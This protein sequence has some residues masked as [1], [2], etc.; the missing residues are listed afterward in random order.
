MS[1]HA[2]L[3]VT[4]PALPKGG[5]AIQGI[6]NGLGAIGSSGTASCEIPLPVSF[7]RGYAPA[8]AL[9]YSSAQ[10]NGVFG[11]GWK[12]TLPLVSRRTQLG[13]P[14]YTR[15]DLFISPDGEVLMPERN[16][17][18]GAIQTRQKLCSDGTQQV[19]HTIVR[20]RPRIES[21]FNLIEH[22]SSAKDDP[23]FWLIH[24]ADGSQHLFGKTPSARRADPDAPTHVGEWLLEESVNPHGEHIVY[25]YN[26]DPASTPEP[27]DSPAQR[28][29]ERV[30]YGNFEAE[31]QLYL[32]IVGG[33][34]D[35]RWHFEL[36]FDYG[37]R[38][39]V[40]DEK[41]A[42]QATKTSPVRSD[43]F[44]DFSY[45][46]ELSTRRLCQ[47]I[48]MFHH[49]P[50]EPSMGSEPV[51]VR[52][53][54][55]EYQTR[56][57]SYSCLSAALDQAYGKSTDERHPPLEFSYTDFSLEPG[58]ERFKPF[59]ALSG[60]NHQQ[61]F[62]FVDLLGE[63][64]PGVLHRTDKSWRYSQPVRDDNGGDRVTYKA[65]SELPQI[66]SADSRQPTRQCL[67]N[68]NANGRPDWILAQP[69]LSGF[70]TLKPNGTWSNFT[71]LDAVPT[72]FFHPH[73]QLANLMGAGL[74]DLVMLGPRSVRLYANQKGAGFASAT[75]VDRAADEDDLPLPGN[76]SSELVAFSDLLGS[77][78]QQ[79]V[80]IRRNEVKCW[81][82]L[83]R[84]RFGKGRVIDTPELSLEAFDASRLLLADL[85][86]SGS[87]D[88]IYLEPHCARIFMNLCGNGLSPAI[89]VPWPTGLRYDRFCQVSATDLQGL[90]CSSLVFSAPGE[91]PRHW[92]CDF[93][94]T[95]P[96]LLQS[97]N[98]NMGA[99]GSLNYRSSA[100]EWLDEK[101]QVLK[102]KKSAVS[103]LPFPLFLVKQQTRLDEITGNRLI[104]K[105]KY[106][107]GFYDGTEREFRGFGL[108]V[109]TDMG[110]DK[111]SNRQ[112]APTLTKTWFH[113]GNE[114]DLVIHDRDYSDE[115]AVQLKETLQNLGESWTPRSD[116]H[117]PANTSSRARRREI[118]RAL[119]GRVLR[120]EVYGQ[121]QGALSKLP[122]S[123]QHHRYKVNELKGMGR[124]S[125][126]SIL[127][128][129]LAESI[130]YQYER[131][132]QDP[133]CT[134][135][136]NLN[137]DA[138]GYLT[139]H[140]E[141]SYARR[142][143][144]DDACPFTD[145]WNKKWWGDAHDEAQQFYYVT[146]HKAQFI[147][148]NTPQKR[149]L[150][151][152]YLQR[153]NALK[154]PKA[155]V[156]EGLSPSTIN[157]EALLILSASPAWKARQV[158][159]GLSLQ[160]YRKPDASG[161]FADG[162]ASVEALV[163]H[164][165]TA[166]LNELALDVYDLLKSQDA[167]FD[168]TRRL[169]LAGYK[170]MPIALPG[171]A[172]RD[173]QDKLWSVRRDFVT[174][175]KLEGFFKSLS[176]KQ[177]SQQGPTTFTH[178]PYFCLTTGLKLPDNCTTTASNID[179]RLLQPTQITDSND[180]V[181]EASLDAF[182]QVHAISHFKSNAD[183]S[184]G[185]APLSSYIRRS[186]GR[187]DLA[188]E[189]PEQ[190]LQQVA[191][192]YFYDAFSWMG[193]IALSTQQERDECEAAVAKGDLLPGGHIRSS[194]R[195]RLARRGIK[196]TPYEQA[197]QTKIDSAQREPVHCATLQA[198]RYPD[199]S[200]NT[201]IR[202]VV[203]S[204]DGFGRS[205]QSKQK[206]GQGTALAVN[207]DGTLKWAD[208]K[209]QEHQVNLR[210]RVSERIEYD[211]KGLVAR[212]YRPYFSDRHRY[213]NDESLRK[214]GLCDQYFHDPLGRLIRVI[215][216]KGDE[217][218]HAWHPWY[219]ITEDENDTQPDLPAQEGAQ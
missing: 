186:Q 170:K 216:A 61:R 118:A 194:T 93:V 129:V 183:G 90:G 23:G 108:I 99:G 151:L 50:D 102:N 7:G 156:A 207:E 135:T 9:R 6:G 188:I 59:E 11:L 100:Q 127:H 38:S 70:F 153:T 53:T 19:E 87:A 103:R 209:P 86:G 208:D 48:L 98:N 136:V 167:S 110:G 210:W 204:R 146:E 201:Q 79:L 92:R 46:F 139:H 130:H 95:K 85:D 82:N 168:L 22:W 184:I 190:A 105:F 20:Y 120:V 173:K 163:D 68:L 52:R 56:P 10:G 37:E 76:S 176:F 41:P 161:P 75:E 132:P 2:A 185:F 122:Y 21:A 13:V 133:R 211:N 145:S 63:G 137:W 111:E 126:Y 202:I 123:V 117:V 158:M 5:G 81:P 15:D 44:S 125:P 175:K 157:H 143:T 116:Q 142:T 154:R 67:G 191:S 73:G 54:V 166:E 51:L 60:L 115:K 45:G 8:L 30:S 1:E 84:G 140:L 33:L 24:N 147:H 12:L 114:V 206:A 121:D 152:P 72:E 101:K 203:A 149:R 178:D 16:R 80:R 43:P 107:R 181:Q 162:Q 29:L 106:R 205:L 144:A 65:L 25:E 66:P 171:D 197:L 91:T 39:T 17:T 3:P 34:K 174:Y 200:E 14:A 89:D 189:N 35:V 26:T 160:R 77:G 58:V 42:Y 64:L 219:S 218:R 124:H 169:E 155:P 214:S 138:Y 69:G 192:T 180:V 198:D 128:P 213:I 148:I 196:K 28:Y 62:Q 177:S 31:A 83:G 109:Q 119:N 131:F 134:H 94:S 164:S 88:F 113:V 215:N 4:P 55:I 74:N 40:L 195:A 32:C 97:T 187:P 112:T 179:Y 159:T 57:H 172:E 49:F 141:I 199:D 212:T 47:Q 165:E 36:L 78:Q 150:G 193:Q 217:R 182:G 71:P 27:A 104:Q 18:T 96:Y